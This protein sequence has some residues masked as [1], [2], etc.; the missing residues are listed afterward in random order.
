M[1]KNQDFPLIKNN[2]IQINTK[3]DKYEEIIDI[4]KKIIDINKIL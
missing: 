1:E 4:N 3:N 2:I